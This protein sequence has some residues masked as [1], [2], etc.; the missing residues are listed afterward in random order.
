MK[1]LLH[2][3]RRKKKST[4]AE[5]QPSSLR[6]TNETVAEHRERILAGGRKFKY[7]LQYPK[8]RIVAI[9]VALVLAAVVSFFGFVLWQLYGVQ[10]TSKF[11][12]NITQIVPV[13]VAEVDKQSVRY[14]DYLVELRSALHYLSTKEAVNL[15]TDDGK[16][17]LDYQKR[18]AINKA[19]QN[20]YV[21]KLAKQQGVAVSD[22]EVNDFIH[23]EI[24]GN[25]LGVTEDVYRQVIRD[26]Y[27]WSFD[28][29][30]HSV[31]H[32]LLRKKLVAKI[33]TEGRQKIENAILKPLQQGAQFADIAKQQS[34]DTLTK[35]N[36]GDIGFVTKTSDDPSGLIDVA[37]KLQPNQT[38]G[39]IEGMDGFYVVKLLETKD[40]S[41]H[42]AK[43]FVAYSAF[44]KKFEA[45]KK[46]GGVKEYIKIS[47]TV[48]AGGT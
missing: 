36:G 35:E 25:R 23:N 43:I 40:G 1:K 30:K 16:R 44:D 17:Q 9:T 3:L 48:R 10:N 6:I 13:P 37:S 41:V 26:Y 7:P 42:F 46:S 29:Y 24:S 15:S 45:L 39:I 20:A 33:D 11:M 38:S 32:Q 2:K 18:L 21:E 34:E 47:E 31:K 5:A 22:K 28:E 14:S 12:Y 19:I 8:H 27:D 4:V